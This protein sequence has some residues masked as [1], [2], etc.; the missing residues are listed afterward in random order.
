MAGMTK[1]VADDMKERLQLYHNK[2][3]GSVLTALRIGWKDYTGHGGLALFDA[4][5]MGGLLVRAKQ[6]LEH[7]GDAWED[8]LATRREKGIISFTLEQAERLIELHELGDRIGADGKTESAKF[9]AI[10]TAR[11][12]GKA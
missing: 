4:Q 12:V 10:L 7:F 3:D 9:T 2:T 1:I 5:R 8:W 11:P 6:V